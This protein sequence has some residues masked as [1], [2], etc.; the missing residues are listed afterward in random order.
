MTS[1]ALRTRHAGVA[2]DGETLACVARDGT[3]S[4]RVVERRAETLAAG[5]GA[6]LHEHAALD[7]I[8]VIVTR[9]LAHLCTVS[10]PA[11]SRDDAERV[12]ARD[13]ERHVISAAAGPYTVAAERIGAGSWRAAFV[14][15]EIGEQV[16]AAAAEAGVPI[17]YVATTDDILAAAA[18]G[19]G[20]T[21]VQLQCGGSTCVAHARDGRADAG[22]TL[23][24]SSTAEDIAQFAAAS[25]DARAT[26][27]TIASRD[28][29]IITALARLAAE[30]VP[31]L[32][33]ASRA[34]RERARERSRWSARWLGAA[35]LIALMAAPMIERWRVDRA[36]VRVADE[37][38][39]I[40][41]RVTPALV[42]RDSLTTAREV[43]IALAQREAAASRVAGAIAAVALAL[44]ACTTLASL[45]VTGDSLAMDGESARSAAV[46]DAL[47]QSSVLTDV[48]LAAPLR[49]EVRSG[50]DSL[51]ERFTFSARLRGG[52]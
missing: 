23:P 24:P 44:P 48:R 29:T 33:V 4:P 10:L 52:R 41:S 7:A 22:R 5:L 45:S 19:R 20:E 18:G 50:A 16:A 9:P 6:L 35:T 12:L 17:A 14:P 47:R 39:A 27:R 36:L 34:T 51:V 42:A 49:Q 21:I 26:V 2:W 46:Y 31:T 13:W 30:A 8:T 32:A 43:A 25:G 37:R 38:R 1:R 28:S 3:A 40:A 15:T 11:M